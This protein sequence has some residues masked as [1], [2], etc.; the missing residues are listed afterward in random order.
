ME[1]NTTYDSVLDWYDYSDELWENRT[2]AFYVL[3]LPDTKECVG[4]GFL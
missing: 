3:F 4:M 1:F 2:D